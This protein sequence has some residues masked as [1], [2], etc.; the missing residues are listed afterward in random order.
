MPADGGREKRLASVIV[1]VGVDIVEVARIQKMLDR[2]QDAFLARV[3]TAQERDYCLKRGQPA[4]SLAA[5]FAAKEALMKVLGTGWGEG[6]GFQQVEVVRDDRGN[7][8]LEL[9]GEAATVATKLGI[10]RLHVSLSHTNDHA[11]ALVVAEGTD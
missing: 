5:R 8:G 9:T 10:H 2:E 4:E 11:V 3:F 1:G 6:V 7:P